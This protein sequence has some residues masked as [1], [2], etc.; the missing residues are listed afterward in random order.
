MRRNQTQQ[1][2]RCCAVNSGWMLLSSRCRAI[3]FISSCEWGHIILTHLFQ[4]T[5]CHIRP[6]VTFAATPEAIGPNQGAC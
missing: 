6:R 4:S 3:V 5:S 2:T 1:P